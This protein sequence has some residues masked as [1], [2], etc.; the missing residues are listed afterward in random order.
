[1]NDM[2]HEVLQDI[3]SLYEKE[4]SPNRKDT[5]EE[6]IPGLTDKSKE[7]SLDNLWPHNLHSD[8]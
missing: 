8:V 7:E 2:N 3:G 5:D 4:T 6:D 1:M